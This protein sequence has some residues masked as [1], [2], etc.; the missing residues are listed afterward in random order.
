M[1]KNLITDNP[2]EKVTSQEKLLANY[3]AIL[4]VL[5]IKSKMRQLDKTHQIK[6]LKKQI[7]RLLTKK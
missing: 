7:A 3:R 6:Q 4:M 2:T 1:N 5:K